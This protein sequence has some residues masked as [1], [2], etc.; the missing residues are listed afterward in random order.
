MTATRF[1]FLEF[2]LGMLCGTMTA[3]V[4]FAVMAWVLS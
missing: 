4:V 3:V 1:T 2:A